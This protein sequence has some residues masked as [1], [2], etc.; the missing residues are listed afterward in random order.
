MYCKHCGREIDDKKVFCWHCGK[1]VN[2]T[3]AG[4]K[5]SKGAHG[6]RN[7]V[8]GITRIPN[9]PQTNFVY[10]TQA[11]VS[12]HNPIRGF[13]PNSFEAAHPFSPQP[14]TEEPIRESANDLPF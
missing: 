10:G 2:P 5:Y 11:P 12:R 8:S 4:Y 6:V 3:S 14:P 7:V 1:R 9:A 13:Q